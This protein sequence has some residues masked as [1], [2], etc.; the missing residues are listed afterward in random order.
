MLR[1]IF[2]KN[3]IIRDSFVASLSLARNATEISE[4]FL[5]YQKA[6]WILVFSRELDIN[7]I[8]PTILDNWD[9]DRIYLPYLGRSVDMMHEIGD[10]I[11]PNVFIPYVAKLEQED[12]NEDTEDDIVGITGAKFLEIYN[13]QK[14][15]YVEDYG[16]SVGGIVVDR[17]PHDEDINTDLMMTYEA[18]I[19]VEDSLDSAYEVTSGDLVPALILCGIIEWKKSKNES[20]TPEQMA[21]RNMITTI[22]LTEEEWG[23][24]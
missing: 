8:L 4:D 10:V 16:L 9:P 15:Y 23:M 1:I 3:P 6:D 22:R 14:D 20:W 18:D 19:Y 24:N 7:I 13:E 5:V 21:V 2:T 11:L 12:T 17:T